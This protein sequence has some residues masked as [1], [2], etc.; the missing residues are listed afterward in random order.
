VKFRGFVIT[1]AYLGSNIVTIPEQPTAKH[2]LTERVRRSDEALN[3]LDAEVKTYLRADLQ[4]FENEAQGQK[5]PM[6]FQVMHVTCHVLAKT[7]K[8]SRAHTRKQFT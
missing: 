7:F 4:N 6:K 8:I 2:C 3:S 1:N 5:F